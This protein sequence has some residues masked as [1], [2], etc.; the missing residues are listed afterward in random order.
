MLET[1]VREDRR[2]EGVSTVF[3]ARVRQRRNQARGRTEV[4]AFLCVVQGHQCGGG[5]VCCWEVPA[6]FLPWTVPRPVPQPVK[7]NDGQLALKRD[8]WRQ[9]E[10]EGK[11]GR[12]EKAVVFAACHGGNSPFEAE[13]HTL[14]VEWYEPTPPP[15]RS[16][17]SELISVLTRPKEEPKATQGQGQSRARAQT[18]GPSAP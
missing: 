5:Q 6:C 13:T 1:H 14:P 9:R 16:W 3:G 18:S 4:M 8:R 2:G 7:L 10:K 17:T 12:K 11:K 15:P